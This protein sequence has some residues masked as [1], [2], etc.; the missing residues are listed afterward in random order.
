MKLDHSCAEGREGLFCDRE[1]RNDASASQDQGVPGRA[2]RH[3]NMLV[4]PI[5][6][7]HASIEDLGQNRSANA[8]GDVPKAQNRS[9]GFFIQL[10]LLEVLCGQLMQCMLFALEE[11]QEGQ[12]CLGPVLDDR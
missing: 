5:F 9:S 2:L 1:V 12:V 11:L 10:S 6:K 8:M 7:E 3:T 4:A